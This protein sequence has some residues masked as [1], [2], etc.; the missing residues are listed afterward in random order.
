MHGKRVSIILLSFNDER[1]ADAIASVR[2]FDDIGAT[3]LVVIDGGSRDA[4]RDMISA[5]LDPSDIFVSEKDKGIF[6]GLNKGLA[7]CDTEFVGWLGSDD[8]FTG[9]VNASDVVRALEQHDLFV[10]NLA[11]VRDGAVTRMTYSWPAR[12]GLV[13]YG[14]N[15]PHFATFGRAPLLRSE[16]F[17]IKNSAADIEYFLK[18]FARRPSVATTREVATLMAVGGYSNSSLRR[19][20]Q[21]NKRMFAAYR[22]QT[23]LPTALAVMPLR[24]AYKL[25]SV[26]IYKA[27]AAVGLRRAKARTFLLEPSS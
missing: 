18:I 15:N 27:G 21:N 23:N 25:G 12:L 26:A 8:V 19:I 4:I 20:L 17:D 24:A 6:D 14:L 16:R 1:I 5:R 13:K 10:A 3:R 7:L 9:K 11:H 2:R 22:E